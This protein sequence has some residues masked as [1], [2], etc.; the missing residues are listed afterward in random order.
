VHDTFHAP[1]LD[2]DDVVAS[3]FHHAD[4]E[5]DLV[6]DDFQSGPES[7][8]A[9]GGGVVTWSVSNLEEGLLDDGNLGFA[10]NENDA[11][12]G[13]TQATSDP[14]DLEAGVVFDWD[15]KDT[16]YELELP[17]GAYDLRPYGYLSFRAAQGTRHP[18]TV[19]LDGPLSFT[20]VLVDGTGAESAIDV[21]SFGLLTETYPRDGEGPGEGWANEFNTIRIPITAF[22]ADGWPID[23]GDIRKVRFAFGPSYGSELGRIGLDD[24]EVSF[25]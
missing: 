18:N 15:G 20:V 4:A 1:A 22:D 13:M 5:P 14:S 11:M 10:W 19:A 12:N 8:A 2:A 25:R 24:V 6:I 21:S 17:K 7:D 3:T 23:L 9:S 16:T